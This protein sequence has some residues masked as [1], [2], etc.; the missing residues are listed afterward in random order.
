MKKVFISLFI[1]L[2]SAGI[3]AAQDLEKAT[4]LY[5]NAAAA[6]ESDKAEAITLFEQ[7]L[8]M[9]GALTDGT[10]IVTNCKD[11][12]PKLYVS[13]GKELASDK[14][15]DEAIEKLKKAVEVAAEYGDAESEEDAKTLIP[16]LLMSDATALLN[17]KQYAEAAAAY[18]KVIDADPENGVAF[19]RKGMALAS[20]GDLD[21]AI[22]ALEAASGFGQKDAAAK[23]LA[24]AFL[25]KAVESQK[26]KDMKSVLEFAQK[27][28]EY[29]DSANAQKLIGTAALQLKQ[30]N[31]AAEAFEAY[32]ALSPEA[33]D[34]VQIIFQLGTALM[35]GGDNAKACG[36]FKQISQDAQFGESARYYITTLKCN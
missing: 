22:E 5:N 7:A 34:K 3:A 12:L 29:T 28:A 15:I 27:S 21:A 20:A 10:E 24:N 13:L 36:Y 2:C 1:V 18:Q 4:E 31:V 35:N 32:L 9:A 6:I 33:K 14:N 30:N 19:L 23:Q 25:K 17:G 8:E 16:Q 11:I 26:E